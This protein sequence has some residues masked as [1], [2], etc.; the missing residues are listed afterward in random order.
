M[1]GNA[2][3]GRKQE[4]PFRDAL[5]LELAAAEQNQRGLR[6]IAKRLIEAAEEGKM[7]AVKEIAD[8]IDGKVPQSIA[9]DDE[10]PIEFVHKIIREI[11]RPNDNASNPNS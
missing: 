8:R 11:V 7:D 10:N 6:L 1:A 2:N 9:G 5:R 3:S 4:K